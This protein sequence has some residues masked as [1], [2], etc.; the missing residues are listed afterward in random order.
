MQ[1]RRHGE[2]KMNSRDVCR[3]CLRAQIGKLDAAQEAGKAR[4]ARKEEV[5]VEEGRCGSAGKKM[6]FPVT[7]LGVAT[8]VVPAER[9]SRALLS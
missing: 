8:R 1:E 2:T 7:R 9:A 5:H 3:R 6:E 4:K